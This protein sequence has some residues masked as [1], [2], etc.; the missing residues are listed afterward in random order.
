M[1]ARTA[2]AWWRLAELMEEAAAK[3]VADLGPEAASTWAKELGFSQGARTWD[4]D[5][6]RDRA[7]V[8]EAH[9][10]PKEKL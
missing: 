7:S 9:R 8:D 4:D 5:W 10:Q 2:A 6:P 1:P 3:S